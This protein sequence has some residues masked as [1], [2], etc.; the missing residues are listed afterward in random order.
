MLFWPQDVDSIEVVVLTFRNKRAVHL[1]F[2][3]VMWVCLANDCFYSVKWGYSTNLYYFV[4]IKSNW[5]FKGSRT[6]KESP[7]LPWGWQWRSCKDSLWEELCLQFHQLTSFPA[8]ALSSLAQEPS[9]PQW[10]ECACG[11]YLFAYLYK[12]PCIDLLQTPSWESSAKS[13]SSLVTVVFRLTALTP[14]WHIVWVP[15]KFC[16]KLGCVLMNWRIFM[17]NTQFRLKWV[18]N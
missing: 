5:A 18:L 13:N 11:W 6:G 7:A 12:R 4:L 3:Q 9:L 8:C 15:T 1:T 14:K 10:R 2:H 17:W 16:F